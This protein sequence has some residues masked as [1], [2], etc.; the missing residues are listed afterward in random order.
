MASPRDAGGVVVGF[1]FDDALADGLVL[2]DVEVPGVFGR[3]DF[4]AMH[5][6]DE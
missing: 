6:E 1:S 5:G 3:W 2:V 4:A